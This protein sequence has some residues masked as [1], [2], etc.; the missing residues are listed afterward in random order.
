MKVTSINQRKDGNFNIQ[1]ACGKNY[2]AKRILCAVEPN[3][4]ASIFKKLIPKKT[5][6]GKAI[7][8]DAFQAHPGIKFII[9]YDKAYWKEDLFTGMCVVLGGKK[10]ITECQGV[11]LT[12]SFDATC[13]V[14]NTFPKLSGIICG[15]VAQ[16]WIDIP[17]HVLQEQLL[18][19]LADL[20]GKSWPKDGVQY[21]KM[22]A[23]AG[24]K[25]AMASTLFSIG[26]M[27]HLHLLR[28][29][30]MDEKLFFAGTA[31]ANKFVFNMAGGAG[32]GQRAA[33]Q[34]IK[35][36]KPETFSVNNMEHFLSY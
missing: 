36:I 34:I 13:N 35:A 25:A 17:T 1:D 12:V 4:M 21:F 28:K 20:V 26:N 11:P 24:E 6:L 27:R 22:K 10:V 18:Q 19:T 32:A 33:A 16:E 31:T 29:P 14:D 15:K 5:D 23:W 8:S 2:A 7:A 30:Q 3:L 9:G